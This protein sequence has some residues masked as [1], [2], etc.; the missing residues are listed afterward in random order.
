MSDDKFI[1]VDLNDEKSGNIAEILKNKSAK[2]ILD[3][4][5]EV[6]EASEKDIADKLTMPLNT[7]E[8]NLKKLISAGFVKKTSNFFWSV[9]GKKIPTYKLS[10][11]HIVISSSRKPDLTNLKTILPIIFIAAI[12][13]VFVGLLIFPNDYLISEGQDKLK[14]FDSLSE[15]KEFLEEKSDEEN[16]NVFRGV[17][18]IAELDSRSETAI[19]S[20]SEAPTASKSAGDY[21]TTNIQVEGVDE[22]D[23]VK[24]DGNYIYLVSGN[25]VYIVNA[26]PAE[27]MGILSEI[28]FSDGTGINQIFINDDKLI[29]FGNSYG[30]YAEE[31]DLDYADEYIVC[32]RAP[33]PPIKLQ[34]P[35]T[36]V[37]IYDISNKNNPQLENKFE[38]DSN[39]INSRMIG[40]YVYLI[41]NKFI[42]LKNPQPPV[43][44]N[45]GIE[46][47]ISPREIHYFDYPDRNYVF[48]TIH[49]INIEN[50]ESTEKVYLTGSAGTIYVSTNNIYLTYQ[51]SQDF[52][53]YLEK[54]VDEVVIPL[55]PEDKDEEI[56]S[57]KNSGDNSY[58]KYSEINNIIY[59]YSTKLTGKEKEEYD[60]KLLDLT[61]DFELAISKEYDKTV[62]HKINVDKDNINYKGVGEV[63][64]RI[65]NQFS[66]DEF[67]SYFRIATTTGTR[68]IT[69]NHLYVLDEDLN[70]IGKVE[71]LAQGEI[72]YSARFIG[73]RAYM[74]TFRQV[75]P[76]YVIDLSNPKKPEVLGYLKITGY[77]SYLHPYDENHI[78]GLGM[79]ATEEGRVQ[80]LKI[81]LFDVTD[82][83]NPEQL[84][85]FEVNDEFGDRIVYSNSEA[86]YDHK[87]F[88]FD[89]EKEL[90]VIPV[91]Y[92]SYNI[93]NNWEYWQGA[94]LFKINLEGIELRKKITHFEGEDNWGDNVRR[95]L[96]MD[97]VLYTISNYKIKATDLLNLIQINELKLSEPDY[98]IIYGIAKPMVVEPRSI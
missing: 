40:K 35:R 5:G 31:Y 3:F 92:S 38:T 68:T 77:S 42:N 27:N 70:I 21:S 59:D 88:L 91:S 98:G 81:A 66:M 96:Y 87:A 63:P 67:E 53:Y 51:K 57:I 29:V 95:S 9:K 46:S 89:K 26:F 79:E 52:K 58:Q 6:K 56:L 32:I 17:P 8:Y 60:Q 15:L 86:T 44:W 41:G 97:N 80:G 93:N 90:L 48:T 2:K 69:L 75:D 36:L 73:E 16:V 4:L 55:L 22:P 74:V 71:D 30:S 14:K 37:Y 7:V 61:E 50:G 39:Y 13:L 45:D 43:Y 19:A 85:K 47:S 65:L 18:G 54:F 72:I 76:F 11:K 12:L 83:N 64:G 33:C 25:K 82:V 20:G 62:I 10:R 23:I 94:Y 1:L 78:I 34:E 84:S 24:N 49:T 28:N